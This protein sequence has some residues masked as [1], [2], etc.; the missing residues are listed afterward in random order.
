M[1]RGMSEIHYTHLALEIWF[2]YDLLLG[3]LWEKI[4]R[5]VCVNTKRIYRN[6]LMPTGHSI[7]LLKSN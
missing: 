1:P 5:K 6:R 4:P 2:V 7:I 3:K